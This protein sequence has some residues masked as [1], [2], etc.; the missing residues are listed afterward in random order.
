MLLKEEEKLEY[1]NFKKD[2][3]CILI[4][5]YLSK[6]HS[7]KDLLNLSNEEITI[8]SY[9]MKYMLEIEL[10]MKGVDING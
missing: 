4:A 5:Y 2:G 7:L 6:G 9:S 1:E 8:Y 10:K 3:E